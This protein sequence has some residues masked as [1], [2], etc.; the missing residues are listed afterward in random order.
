ME[1]FFFIEDKFLEINIVYSLA[2]FFGFVYV[3]CLDLVVKFDLEGNIVKRYEVEKYII[4]VV[5][6]KLDEIIS[7]SC[8]ISY[9]I[10][11][12]DF[13]EKLYSYF[14][15]K[16]KYFYGFDV[17]FFGNIFVVGSDSNNIYVLIFKVELLKIFDIELFKCIKFKENLYVCFVGF[18][19]KII[20]V[21]KFLEDM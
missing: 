17:N 14:Y 10:V 20:K 1:K 6:N 19:K 15:E 5:I 4:F 13:G 18:E 2:I 21:Y 16:L 8:I 7:F 11:M 12:N 3:V 9:V